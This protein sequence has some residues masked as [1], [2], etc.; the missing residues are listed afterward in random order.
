MITLPTW[1]TLSRL[2]LL[3]VIILLLFIPAQTTAWLAFSLYAIASFTDFIDGWIARRYNMESDFGKF[4]DPISD[5]IFVTC[6]LITFV[7]I[8]RLPDF[9]LIPVMLILTREFLVSGMREFLGPRNITLHVTFLAKWKTTIQ[10][11]AIGLLIIAP[12][13]FLGYTAAY[14]TLLVSTFLT[15]WTGWQYL[16]KGVSALSNDC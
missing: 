4:L 7:A 2:F 6:L 10:M 12:Y 1:I 3:P 5:K 11:A 16:S 14:I 13:V 15:L 9:W 8:G